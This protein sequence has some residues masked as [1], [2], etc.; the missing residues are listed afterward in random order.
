M[1]IEGIKV[2]DKFLKILSKKFEKRI[3]ELETRIFKIS[4][5]EL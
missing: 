5:K 1:E 4:K 2:E 3:Q